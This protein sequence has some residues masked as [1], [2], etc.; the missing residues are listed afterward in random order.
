MK[1]WSFR[2]QGE[3]LLQEVFSI[4]KVETQQVNMLNVLTGDGCWLHPS[5][6]CLGP[7][8]LG[9]VTKC[10]KAQ[11]PER[12]GKRH[13]AHSDYCH[14]QLTGSWQIHYRCSNDL[15]RHQDVNNKTD[16]NRAL[17]KIPAHSQ[18][19]ESLNSFPKPS[20]GWEFRS[21]VYS[22]IKS[23]KE[24]EAYFSW[25]D[26]L[27]CNNKEPPKFSLVPHP[28]SL[29]GLSSSFATTRWVPGSMGRV[30]VASS[31]LQAYI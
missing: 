2:T 31:H 20:R 1:T 27:C 24:D 17:L 14:F 8:A 13:S 30:S 28:I 4:R 29:C 16:T 11:I 15:I 22:I 12:K 21:L 25:V 7:K 18:A 10:P 26:Q 6:W 3:G 19:L 23:F 5:L 9:D